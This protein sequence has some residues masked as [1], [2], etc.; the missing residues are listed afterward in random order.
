VLLGLAAAGFIIGRLTL[1]PERGSGDSAAPAVAKGA[2]AVGLLSGIGWAIVRGQLATPD[3]WLNRHLHERMQRSR[4]PVDPT[5]RPAS[6]ASRNGT[7]GGIS[8][9]LRSDG[10][11]SGEALH[12]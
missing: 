4:P 1:R 3:S 8:A 6:G 12:L 7:S 11:R 5:I 2:G 9:T 10:A